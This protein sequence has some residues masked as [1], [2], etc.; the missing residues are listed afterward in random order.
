MNRPLRIGLIAE[1]QTELGPSVPYVK[2]EDGGKLIPKENEGALHTLIRRELIDAGLPDCDFVQRHPST[3]EIRKGKVTTGFG[4]L[5]P[6]YLSQIAITWKPEEVD[7]IIILADADDKISERQKSLISALKAIQENHL[8]ASEKIIKDQSIG[9]LAIKNFE[10]WLLADF[11]T[12]STILSIKI[13]KLSNLEES[14]Q[15][16][17]ILEN[18]IAESNYLSEENNRNLRIHKIK[19]NLAFQI[20]LVILKK[21]CSQ[22]Y[23]LFSQDLLKL[24]QIF[25][26]KLF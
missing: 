3:K 24:T 17:K 11:Q 14:D 1:G 8:D 26:Q 5:D 6:K 4:F 20:D 16:K 10:A 13:P 19:W 15:T 12:V 25:I 21:N 18:A 9:G 22:G 2:P 7:L 23:G